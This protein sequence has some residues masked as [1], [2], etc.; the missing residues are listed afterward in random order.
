M[1]ILLV[2]FLALTAV[3]MVGQYRKSRDRDALA[4]HVRAHGGEIA[5]LHRLRKGHPFPDTGRGWWAWRIDWRAGTAERTSWAL[6]TREG[7]KEWRD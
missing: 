6:T 4:A 7:I 1:Q 5:R 2:V 3:F